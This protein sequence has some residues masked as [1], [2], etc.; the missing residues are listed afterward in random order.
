MP[1]PLI[2]KEEIRTQ[3][4]TKERPCEDIG[5]RQPSVSQGERLQQ[6]PTPMTP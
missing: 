4:H 6:K 2:R 3:T 5:R 1:G